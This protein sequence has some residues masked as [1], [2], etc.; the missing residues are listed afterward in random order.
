M[1]LTNSEEWENLK[2]KN[3]TSSWEDPIPKKRKKT[4][5]NVGDQDA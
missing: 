4:G 1:F 5:F 3:A 2:S